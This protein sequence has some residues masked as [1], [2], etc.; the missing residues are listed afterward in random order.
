MKFGRDSQSRSRFRH[1]IGDFWFPEKPVNMSWPLQ[2]ETSPPTPH[3]MFTPISWR[4]ETDMPSL[5]RHVQLILHTEMENHVV[6]C[7]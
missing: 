4:N 2:R 5:T 7:N 6:L 1:Q 3:R